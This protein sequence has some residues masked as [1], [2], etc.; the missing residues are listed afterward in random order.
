MAFASHFQFQK[1]QCDVTNVQDVQ[2]LDLFRCGDDDIE[3][4]LH[5]FNIQND[6]SYIH[7]RVILI[8][9]LILW[10]R[11]DLDPKFHPTLTLTAMMLNNH[12][13]DDHL[14]NDNHD[15]KANLD[16]GFH[17][18]FMGDDFTRLTDS[19]NMK[20]ST[21]SWHKTLSSLLLS[22][23]NFVFSVNF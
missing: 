21:A 23:L 10:T 7:N 4:V 16:Q 1:K 17:P 22:Y 12:L 20:Y 15:D 8:H 9:N 6:Q 3:Y 19:S 5:I 2:Y 11:Q 18:T 13:S 14:N